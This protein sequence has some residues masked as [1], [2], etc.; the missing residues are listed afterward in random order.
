MYTHIYK[1]QNIYMYKIEQRDILSKYFVLTCGLSTHTFSSIQTYVLYWQLSSLF[2]LLLFRE[3]H[4][5]QLIRIIL[6]Q[7]TKA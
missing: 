5:H 6:K 2:R 1:I 3:S 4:I 7:N